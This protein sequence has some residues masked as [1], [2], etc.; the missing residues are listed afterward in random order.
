VKALVTVEVGSQLS[1]M[2]TEVKADFND[3][4]K[5][6]ALLAVIDRAPFEAK[7]AYAEAGLAA[8]KSALIQAEATVERSS[9]ELERA[10]R[11]AARHENLAPNGGVSQAQLDQARTQ[12]RSARAGLKVARGQ[13]QGAH[14]TVAQHTA[15]LDQA[16]VDLTRTLV[17]SPIDGIVVDRRVQA[18]QTVAAVYATPVLFTIAQDLAQIEIW[19]QVDE[20]D[21]GD[22]RPGANVTFSVEAFP[23]ETYQGTVSQVRLASARNGGAVTYTVIIRAQNPGQRLLPDM[24]ATVRIVTARQDQALFVSN[25]V[26]RFRG[27]GADS[28]TAIGSA[29]DFMLWLK[30]P[31]GS[32]LSR[33]VKLGLKGD[34]VTE[35]I[36]PDIQEGEEVAVRAKKPRKQQGQSK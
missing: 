13:L 9:A 6:G 36:G 20:A 18:G 30:K 35:V 31:D 14:A 23:N 11:D 8:A 34:T 25:D 28:D 32:L 12:M 5:T 27:P 15:E 3:Q 22:V 10:E 19:A 2:I 26:L 16:K 24:T 4:V 1:G 7:V 33:R 21:I 17:T 29:N